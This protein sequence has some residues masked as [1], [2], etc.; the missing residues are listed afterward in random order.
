[1]NLVAE[2]GQKKMLGKMGYNLDFND[3]TVFDAEVFSLIASEFQEMEA[4]EMK[5]NKARKR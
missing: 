2:Y 4:Q 5:K 3:L 1:M